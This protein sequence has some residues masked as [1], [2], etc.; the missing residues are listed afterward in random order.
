MSDNNDPPSEKYILVMK[1][2]RVRTLLSGW[3]GHSG[4]CWFR[5]VC[6]ACV[7]ATCRSCS[8]SSLNDVQGSVQ[9]SGG[10]VQEQYS[11]VHTTVRVQTKSNNSTPSVPSFVVHVHDEA[12]YIAH[13]YLLIVTKNYAE[14]NDAHHTHM[15][16]TN[17]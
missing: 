1:Q 10:S 8:V 2:R 4:P 11:V 9:P 12:A 14:L 3:P 13:F 16:Y 5:T 15:S 17:H 7:A 6:T